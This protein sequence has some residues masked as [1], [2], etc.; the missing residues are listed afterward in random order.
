MAV[1]A[2]GIPAEFSFVIGFALRIIKVPLQ[3]GGVRITGG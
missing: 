1:F 2:L 3:D